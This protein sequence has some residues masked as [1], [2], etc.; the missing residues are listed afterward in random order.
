MLC[1]FTNYLFWQN[2]SVCFVSL[3][4]MDLLINI[5]K[6]HNKLLQQSKTL[7]SLY[8]WGPSLYRDRTACFRMRTGSWGVRSLPPRTWVRDKA[9]RTNTVRTIHRLTHL[10]LATLHPIS[11]L[12]LRTQ[13]YKVIKEG[14][15]N[16]YAKKWCRERGKTDYDFHHFCARGKKAN[17]PF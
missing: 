1:F 16:K 10:R 11:L 13:S 5:S 9:G 3:L 17:K 4:W 7:L 12:P 2:D 15:K 6:Y 8:V 14:I